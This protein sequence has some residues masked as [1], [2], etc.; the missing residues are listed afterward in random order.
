MSY[1]TKIK[2]GLGLVS[3]TTFTSLEF[4]YKIKPLFWM[5]FYPLLCRSDH[6][7]LKFSFLASNPNFKESNSQKQTLIFI[8]IENKNYPYSFAHHIKPY[9]SRKM[10]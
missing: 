1:I 3:Q 5:I 7:P 9:D 4:P 2:F 8:E 6:R 10:Y